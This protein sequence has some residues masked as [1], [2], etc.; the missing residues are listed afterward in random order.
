MPGQIPMEPFSEQVAILPLEINRQK[1][2]LGAAFTL[3]RPPVIRP[4]LIIQV[5]DASHKRGVVLTFRPFDRFSLSFE[6]SERVVRMV[7]Y[8]IIVDMASLRAAFGAR[9]NVNV[10]HALLS[11]VLTK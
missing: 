8:N 1:S 10:R 3:G 9:F 4:L 2:K 5:P 6:G 11:W 7:F